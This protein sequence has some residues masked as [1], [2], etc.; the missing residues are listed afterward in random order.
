MTLVFETARPARVANYAEAT[1]AHMDR[2]REDG[3]RSTVGAPI[4]IEGRVWGVMGVVTT[5]AKPLPTDTEARL[6]SFTE[7]V[8]MAI[9]NTQARTELA[10]S[11]A[12]VVAAADETRRQI[13]RDLHDG[14]QQRLVQVVIGLKL[15]L[16]AL[17]TATPMLG[18][19]PHRRCARPSRQSACAAMRPL[20]AQA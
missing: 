17:D 15:V 20:I 7:L 19:G 4:I 16:Q 14:A 13:Q 12:R 18:N 10:A 8:A 6:A 1:G 9:A 3:I 5:Q 2:L 11:R